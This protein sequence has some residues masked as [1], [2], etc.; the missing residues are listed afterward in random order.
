MQPVKILTRS[1]L[2]Y[3]SNP[4]LLI[5]PLLTTIA[6]FL[7][8]DYFLASIRSSAREASNPAVMLSFLGSMLVFLLL[9]AVV[10]LLVL[11]GQASMT[12]K[13]VLTGKTGLVDLWAG[14]RK[15]FWRVFG[16]GAVFVG[17][18]L[19]IML[20]VGLAFAFLV[21]LPAAVS[22]PSTFA[23]N[24]S[25]PFEQPLYPLGSAIL[26]AL[27][28]LIFEMCLAPVVLDDKG[29]GASITSSLSAVKKRWRVFLAFLGLF[30]FVSAITLV[31]SFRDPSTANL[32]ANSSGISASSLPRVFAG[33]VGA[34]FSPLWFLIAFRIYSESGVSRRDGTQALSSLADTKVCRNC[35]ARIPSYAKFCPNCGTTQ[36]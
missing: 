24:P 9:L 10:G 23:A 5:P 18:V 7:I 32:M 28:T 14:L 35:A 6:S 34:V 3:K 22:N 12:G 2:D 4:I 26:G 11:V 8:S 36:T 15:Y 16:I 31:V 17:I 1:L 29:V 21:I 13:V 19:G 30:S 27:G 25:N 33:L 20:I